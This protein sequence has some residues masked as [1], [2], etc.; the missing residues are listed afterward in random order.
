VVDATGGSHISYSMA[1]DVAGTEY[2]QAGMRSAQEGFA[3]EAPELLQS[4][5]E[6]GDGI[7]LQILTVFPN[8]VLQQIRNSLAVRRVVPRGLDRTE[9]VW[10]AFGFA[11]DD[12]EM[13]ERRLRQA[14]LMG[15]AG[16]I[17][18]E[19]GAATG[20]VQ[21]AVD[22]A[23]DFL[24]VVEMGGASV[25]SDDNRVTEASVRGFWKAYRQHM[26]F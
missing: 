4:V 6:F 13:T 8:F 9:L 16:Y 18:M 3:L 22:A 17:S 12:A 15:P 24:S 11:T 23:P 7:G 2:E 14:N 26:A 20:F 10:T 25:A 1:A 21:R 19:D 5:D